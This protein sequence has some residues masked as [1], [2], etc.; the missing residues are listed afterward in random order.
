MTYH[1]AVKGKKG[2]GITFI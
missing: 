2:N 1:L